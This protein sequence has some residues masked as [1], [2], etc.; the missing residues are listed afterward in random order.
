MNLIVAIDKNNGIGKNGDLLCHLSADLKH[1]KEITSGNTVIMGYNTL[2][3]LPKSAPLK[4]RRNIVLY[5]KDVE[6]EGAEVC[7]SL[8][9]LLELVKDIDP[10]KLFV[11]GGAMVYTLLMPYCKKLYIT[12]IEKEFEADRFLPEIKKNEWR[13][14]EE[15]E[16]ME[17]NSL[18]FRY[19]TYERI[20]G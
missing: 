8:E 1:F 12:H 9:E 14:L 5:E 3:S 10:D 13:I 7:H 19:V 16:L 20:D 18:Q 4:N 11:I 2:I 6:I 15:S 17:E